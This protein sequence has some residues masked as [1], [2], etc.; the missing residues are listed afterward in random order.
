M[1]I[2]MEIGVRF[3]HQRVLPGFC[4][5]LLFNLHYIVIGKCVNIYMRQM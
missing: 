5:K 1:Y 2:E 3:P 4:L